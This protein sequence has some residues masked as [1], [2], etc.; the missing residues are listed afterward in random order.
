MSVTARDI[1]KMIDHSLLRPELTA[2]EVREGCKL[3][4][5]YDVA[6][7][8]VKPCDLGIATEVL[9]GTGVLPATV[10]GFP[11][12]AH[13]TAAKVFEAEEAIRGCARELDMVLNIGRLKS[14]QFDYVEQD[15]KAVVDAAHPHGVIVKVILENCYLTEIGRASCRERV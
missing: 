14:R 1:A 11:H 4:A 13:T 6:T 8:C 15:V 10:V 7:V 5:E 2:E 9:R 3:A 12:G